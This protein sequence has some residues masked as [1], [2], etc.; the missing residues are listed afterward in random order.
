MSYADKLAVRTHIEALNAEFA[1]LIDNGHSERVPAL[2]TE[3]G[4][5]SIFDGRKHQVS[6]GRAAI[7]AA[8]AARA[9]RGPRTACHL[10]TNLH[11]EDLDER[12]AR[13]QCILLLFAHD[14]L[15]PH[16]AVPLMVA[17]YDDVYVRGADGVWRYRSRSATALFVD[18]LGQEIALPL[19]QADK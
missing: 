19:G 12:E 15:A 1:Y 5:Y 16:P 18:S 11:I 8:Y 10:F 13:G 14:G 17:R 3:D 6:T 2:F 9:A 7:A 4:S